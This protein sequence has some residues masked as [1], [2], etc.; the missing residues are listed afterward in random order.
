MIQALA[1]ILL[2][3]TALFVVLWFA[4]ADTFDKSDLVA[5]AYFAAVMTVSAYHF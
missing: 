1:A 4:T 5:A 3:I 2:I